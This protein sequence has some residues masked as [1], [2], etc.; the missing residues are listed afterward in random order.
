MSQELVGRIDEALS[1]VEAMQ[2]TEFLRG[3]EY[4][5]ASHITREYRTM[6]IG[7]FEA[8]GIFTLVNL[9]RTHGQQ[10][11]QALA[12]AEVAGDAPKPDWK[13]WH[14]KAMWWMEQAKRLGYI[15]PGDSACAEALANAPSAWNDPILGGPD[16][17]LATRPAPGREGWRMVPAEPT[18]G[19]GSMM[20]AGIHAFNSHCDFK[21]GLGVH[22]PLK[23]AYRAMI[24]AAPAPRSDV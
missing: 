8:K 5:A 17:R 16:A 1:V 13:F 6:Q 24:A 10:I 2:R 3:V 21:A 15:P 14:G 23:A 18:M 7:E 4:C 11:R 22:G 12:G 19:S 20:D 9:L